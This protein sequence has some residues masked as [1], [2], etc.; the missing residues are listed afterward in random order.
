MLH[1]I[2]AISDTRLTPYHALK[3]MLKQA[4]RG[5]IALFQLRD[6][7]TPDSTLAPLCLPLMDLCHLH[8]IPFILNDRIELAISLQ[9]QGLHI[10][11][12]QDNT[13]YNLDELRQIRT[14]FQGILGISCYGDLTLA[15]NAKLIGADYIA[16]GSC[17][18]STTKPSA[19]TIPLNIFTQATPL[20]IPMCAIG[21]IQKD[22]IAQLKNAQMA[23]CISSI[24]QNDI[25]SNVKEL[26]KNFK[27]G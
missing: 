11:K 7:N 9:T 15:K 5:G 8:Q 12:K 2:Y 27:Q 25:P 1:G 10:G 20:N 24:W 6:K 22:N 4:I 21:G 26:L 23:A 14:K 13:P 17:F 18:K 16:F 19:K 3:D